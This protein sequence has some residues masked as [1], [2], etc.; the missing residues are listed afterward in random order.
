MPLLRRHWLFRCII[1]IIFA[2]DYAMPLSCR[3]FIA[4][5]LI[6]CRPIF[7]FSPLL[8]LRFIFADIFAFIIAA[9][10]IFFHC[11]LLTP[12]C[13]HFRHF[14]AIIDAYF[15]FAILLLI[16]LYFTLLTPLISLFCFHCLISLLLTPLRHAIFIYAIFIISLARF[17]LFSFSIIT[18]IAFTLLFTI[19]FHYYC[20]CHFSFFAFFA[21]ADACRHYCAC[22]F[23][24]W[25]PFSPCRFR[26][27]ADITIRYF[28]TP[29]FFA[30]FFFA[31]LPPSSL[32]LRWFFV[33][34]HH[35]LRHYFLHSPFS[36]FFRLSFLRYFDAIDITP[37]PILR[38][39]LMLF[40]FISR[41]HITLSAAFIGCLHSP[42]LLMPLI[43]PLRR[44]YATL[45]SLFFIDFH[46]MP[47][48]FAIICRHWFAFIRFHYWLFAD[49]AISFHAAISLLFHYFQYFTFCPRHAI[50]FDYFHFIIFIIRRH[51]FDIY[52]CYFSL[53]IY[54]FLFHAFTL[55]ILLLPLLRHYAITS[56]LFTPFR[57]FFITPLRHYFFDAGYFTPLLFHIFLPRRLFSLIADAAAYAIYFH[58]RCQM[59]SRRIVFYFI[60]AIFMPLL[61]LI[62]IF[63][64][65]FDILLSLLSLFHYCWLMPDCHF[66]IADIFIYWLFLLFYFL[67]RR[68]W[69]SFFWHFHYFSHFHAAITLLFSFRFSY[70]IHFISSFSLLRA[71]FFHYYYVIFS[72][73]Y[74]FVIISFSLSHYFHFIIAAFYFHATLSSYYFHDSLLRFH[75]LLF[76]SFHIFIAFAFILIRFSRHIIIFSSSSSFYFQHITGFVITTLL[77]SHIVTV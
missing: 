39:C 75:F 3:L 76:I 57:L 38:H 58:F 21:A 28:I 60:T 15:R 51:H 49:A 67:R 59:F 33:Y 25:L 22:Y 8:P 5:T 4:I 29:R 54:C 13:F 43:S 18:I 12:L 2:A 6:F 69:F 27:Y 40:W 73:L 35:F 24:S 19:L 23:A 55:A 10:A 32:I 66:F 77:P 74:A 47:H 44:H 48:C 7:T 31:I 16:S 70:F 30:I 65:F 14:D 62:F 61:L 64:S 37:P 53:L 50:I 9:T 17:S 34:F 71:A 20:H 36:Y 11:W 72:L 45:L 41:R 56:L 52:Y 46:A 26:W 68:H 42:L 1:D 63:I